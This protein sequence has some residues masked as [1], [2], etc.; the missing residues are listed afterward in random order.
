MYTRNKK[1]GGRGPGDA[2]DKFA[3]VRYSDV[4]RIESVKRVN[5]TPI[6]RMANAL[7]RFQSRLWRARNQ[8]L[9]PTVIGTRWMSKSQSPLSDIEVPS[10]FF[11]LHIV[12]MS[13]PELSTEG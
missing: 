2:A 6:S 5:R 13:V 12:L 8:S 9:F 11:L 1:G 10:I 4:L 7:H 3:G